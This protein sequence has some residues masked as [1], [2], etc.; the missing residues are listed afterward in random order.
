MNHKEDIMEQNTLIPVEKNFTQV[1]VALL[2]EGINYF[3]V[4]PDVVYP[5]FLAELGYPKDGKQIT[6]IELEVARLCFTR[7]LKELYSPDKPMKLKILKRPAWALKNFPIGK[8]LLFIREYN[9]IRG[10]K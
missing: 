5:L 10:I 9:R 7:D 2:D 3:E 8:K 6:Q 1:S 4:D